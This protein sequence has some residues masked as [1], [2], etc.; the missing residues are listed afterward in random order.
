MSECTASGCGIP[1]AAA[2]DRDQAKIMV[3]LGSD[4]IG[5]GD[6]ELGSKLMI[7]F[8]KTLGEM[9][10]ELWRLVLINNGVKLAV[11]DSPVYSDLRALEKEGRTILCCG[12]CLAHFGLAEAEKAGVTTN[13]VD[14]VTAM[15]LADKVI[16]P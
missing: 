2:Q 10:S 8:I 6:D 9:G 16:C 4:V 1:I 7:N 12:T 14:I 5:S 3:L 11:T 15:Q 13:M